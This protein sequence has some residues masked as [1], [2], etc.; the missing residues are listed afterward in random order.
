MHNKIYEFKN[1]KTTYNLEQEYI[2][3]IK[4]NRCDI[5]VS[6]ALFFYCCPTP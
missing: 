5:K 2:V 3:K 6:I 4:K 1:I